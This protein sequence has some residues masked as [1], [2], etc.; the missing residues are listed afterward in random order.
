[1]RTSNARTLAPA[2]AAA[3]LLVAGCSNAASRRAASDPIGAL[4]STTTTTTQRA[5]AVA[6]AAAQAKAGTLD[7]AVFRE[8]MKRTVWRRAELG[9]VR[10]AAIDALADDTA[11]EADT[12][13]MLVLLLPTETNWDVI[14]H[15]C[16]V[17]TAHTWTGLT[18]GLVRSWSRPVAEPRDPD[19]PERAALIALHPDEDVVDVV[20]QV[21]ASPGKDLF[22]DRT[23]TDAWGLLCRVDPTGART[24]ALLEGPAPSAPDPFIADLRASAHDLQ[25][26]PRTGPQLDWLRDLRKPAHAVF[27]TEC[28]AAITTLG[29]E[30][31][32]GLEIRHAAAVRWAAAHHPEWLTASRADM[33]ARA[34]AA[35]AGASIHRRS[36][37]VGDMMRIPKETV[38]SE[39]DSLV[40][41]DCVLVLIAHEAIQDPEVAASLFAQAE[42]D[43]KDGTTEYG[44]VL[45]AAP[46]ASPGEP[47]RFTATSYPPRPAQRAGDIRFVASADLLSAGAAA[48]FHYHFHAQ[49]VQNSEYAGPGPGDIEYAEAFG[50]S[51]IVFTF[52]GRDALDAD[53][54]QPNGARID[55]GE[56]RRPTAG[57]P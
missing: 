13:Q 1:M 18:P 52:V 5:D 44:G 45:D 9:R 4:N 26:I 53:Y 38:E 22:A 10:N 57:K 15:I 41:G 33:L 40:W 47:P 54:Y 17:A 30:Q 51:C 6:A 2:L 31:R 48:L 28:A 20:F 14:A 56:V 49:K 36:A 25:A 42:A 37:D 21:F 39:A 34:E 43:R 7:P 29:P 23:R 3:A 35:L 24:R 11:N 50:R 8:Q 12:V 32:Q 27:W 19:R 55:L 46:A 16:D